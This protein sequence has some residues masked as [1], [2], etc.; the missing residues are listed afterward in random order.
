[1]ASTVQNPFDTTQQ[2]QFSG[3]G[4]V[5]GQI[6]GG[7]RNGQNWDFM[8]QQ[9][10]RLTSVPYDT[11]VKDYQSNG[12]G[13]VRSGIN[14]VNGVP[15]YNFGGKSTQGAPAELTTSAPATRSA[16][17]DP[18][19]MPKPTGMVNSP[20]P[21]PKPT[22]IVAGA[23]TGSPSAGLS[24]SQSPVTGASP[25]T[26]TP[27]TSSVNQQTETVAGQMDSILAT[28]SPLMQRA[29]TLAAQGMNQRGL[30]N[31]SMS[32]GAGVAAMIDRATPIAQQDA[33]TYSNRSLANLDAVNGA[34]QFNAA[35]ANQLL[36]Q[37][38]NI[39]ANKELATA[40]Q[41]FQSAQAD[42]DRAFQAVQQDKSIK[43]QTDLQSAQMSFQQAQNQLDRAQQLSIS[44]AQ[45]ASNERLTMAQ[46]DAT[47]KNLNTSNQAQMEQMK[48]QIANNQTEAGKNYAA[49]LTL[50]ATNQ[51]NALLADPNLSSKPEDGANGVSPKQAAIDNLINSTNSSLQWASTFYNTTLPRYTAPGGASSSIKPGARYSQDQA[52]TALQ[53]LAVTDPNASYQDVVKSAMA[54]GYTLEQINKAY[55][56]VGASTSKPLGGSA[57]AT[58]APVSPAPASATQAVDTNQLASAFKG[59]DIGSV[60]SLISGS[61]LGAAQIKQLYGLNDADI[62]WMRG[63]GVKV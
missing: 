60:N 6:T 45:V 15:V 20:T 28:D 21:I 36:S 25:Q 49:T 43:A 46:I 39:A 31:S 12:S 13:S 61:N 7:A 41:K 51:I 37:N 63:Q 17:V 19:P 57:T 56:S 52:N 47:A 23:I 48:T 10:N 40:Q 29:R 11:F 50:N 42:L 3:T 26:Y 38:L 55:A 14:A 16:S 59:G 62:N 53:S 58:K 2:K 9:G 32:Q 24:T 54:Q 34:G 35:Q 18:T 5:T 8:D 30:V 33:Q 1:M 4:D 27:Q 44:N 22:G